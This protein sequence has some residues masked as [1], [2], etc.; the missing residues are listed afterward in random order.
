M[1]FAEATG[2]LPAK[3][4]CIC[5]AFSYIKL[6][7]IYNNVARLYA[8]TKKAPSFEGALLIFKLINLSSTDADLL[9][10]AALVAVP[11]LGPDFSKVMAVLRSG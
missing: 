9:D 4:T 3:G 5:G 6:L 1:C 10:L 11:N 7:N 2:R 8:V